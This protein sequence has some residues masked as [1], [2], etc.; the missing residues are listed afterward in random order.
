MRVFTGSCRERREDMG[1]AWHLIDRR[2]S[3]SGKITWTSRR[4]GFEECKDLAG[5]IFY[6]KT[7]VY[8][9]KISQ[10]IVGW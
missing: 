2:I 10:I 4:V 6:K 3:M 1:V 5:R 9:G 8:I 7:G